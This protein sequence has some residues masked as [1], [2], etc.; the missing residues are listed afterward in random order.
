MIPGPVLS[1]LLTLVLHFPQVGM[2]VHSD[3]LTT[4]QEEPSDSG[5]PEWPRDSG[6]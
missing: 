4:G 5:Q 6:R 2:R 3:R 1:Y